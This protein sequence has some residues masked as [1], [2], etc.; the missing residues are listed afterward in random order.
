M[1]AS[2]TAASAIY[3]QNHSNTHAAGAVVAMI[4]IYYACYNTMMP[5]TYIFICEVFPFIH[6]SKGVAVTQLFTRAG[7]GFNMFIN[8]MGLEQ[9][10]WKFYL[11]YVAWLAVETTV[12][13]F[14]YPE[15]K[16]PSLEEVSRV[17]EGRQKFGESSEAEVGQQNVSPKD[18]M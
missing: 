4:F 11:V 6:R 5:L 12:I 13:Y 3:D 10:G 18:R 16:G 9:I 7:S 1:F 15:T 2:W 14:L 8:P 17:M